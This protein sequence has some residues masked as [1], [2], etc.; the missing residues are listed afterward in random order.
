MTK[1]GAVTLV[2]YCSRRSCANH[3]Y[4]IWRSTNGI[5]M[6]G[7]VKM[8]LT[9]MANLQGAGGRQSHSHVTSYILYGG[10]LIEYMYTGW[11]QNDFVWRITPEICMV[12][13]E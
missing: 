5:I 10:S 4:F 8:T 2:E 7:G 1:K 11:C 12:V 3:I 6:Q 13:S 9:S